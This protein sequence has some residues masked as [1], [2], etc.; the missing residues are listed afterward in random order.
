MCTPSQSQA[1][2]TEEAKAE[3]SFE[4]EEGNGD[5]KD[6][7]EEPGGAGAKIQ[8]WAVISRRVYW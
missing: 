6:A 8:L 2:E 5:A 7:M 4:A 1:M 3:T